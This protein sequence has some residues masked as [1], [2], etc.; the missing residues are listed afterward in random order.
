MEYRPLGKSGIEA[1]IVGLGTWAIGGWMWGGTEEQAS[2][3]AIKASVDLGVNLIDTAPAY[4]LGY[5]EEIVGKAIEGIR[6]RVIIATKC[7]LVWHTQQGTHFFD[8]DGKPVYR[9]LGADSIRYEVEQ[10]L[11]RMKIDWIDLYQTHWQ[12]HTTPIE[13]TMS[14]LLQLKQE[15]KI[16]AIGVS[17]ANVDQIREYQAVGQFDTDQEKYSMLDR[18]LEREQLPYLIENDIAFL[19]Y[20]PLA[21]GLLSGKMTPDRTFNE[22]DQRLTNPRFSKENRMKIKQM[23]DEF[24]QAKTN[25]HITTAQLAIAWTFTQPGV[26]HVLIGARD[27]KQAEENAIAGDVALNRDCLEVMDEILKRYTPQL[28]L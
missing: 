28:V 9:Y 19:A 10:S 13:E 22:G 3:D 4:G 25:H 17:N 5:S 24:E 26:T 20:S 12:D 14:T 27:R 2:I 6:D 15:G 1:S 7:G 8:Q 21:L 11:K 16:R 18:E 23:L